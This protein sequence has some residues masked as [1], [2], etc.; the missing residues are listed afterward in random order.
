VTN[1]RGP[2]PGRLADSSQRLL[3]RGALLEGEPALEAWREWERREEIDELDGAS[4]GLVGLLYRNLE[5]HG[6]DHPT[7]PKLKGVYRHTWFN[8]QKVLRQAGVPIRALREAGIPTLALKGATLCP[9][10][11]RDWGVRIMEDFDLLVPPDQAADA[12]AVLRR[13]GA[14]PPT[15][16]RAEESVHL[17]HSVAFTH[18]DGWEMDLHWYSLW[19]S[20]SDQALWE[21]A[22]PLDVGGEPTLAPGPTH[23]LLL[24]CVH[25]ADWAPNKPLRAVADA[26]AV[27]QAGEVDWDLLVR[28]AEERLLTLVLGSQLEY[29]R[30]VVDAPVPDDVLRRLREAPK[31]RFERVGF[32]Q[33]CRPFRPSTPLWMIWERHRRLKR[34][35][36]PG[37]TP[38]G[39]LRCYYDFLS[40]NWGVQGPW[41]FSRRAGLAAVRFVNRRFSSLRTAARAQ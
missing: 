6:V 25:G 5:A 13:I 9:L 17:R 20:G 11:Y 34:L 40:L 18:P 15:V 41:E 7:M 36:P 31:P 21:H 4:D 8:N 39:L 37:P 2:E 29:L 1:P 3:L 22:V 27:I 38:P 23:Q 16:P 33:T 26:T 32:K 10:Y 12:M 24:V 14:T 30:D 28:E 19:R 35:R